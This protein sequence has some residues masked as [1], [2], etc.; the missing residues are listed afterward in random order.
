MSK[1]LSG[2]G[3]SEMDL[4]NFLLVRNWY[5]SVVSGYHFWYWWYLFLIQ[6]EPNTFQCL[7]RW[8]AT[9]QMC[10]YH[11]TTRRNLMFS[12]ILFPLVKLFHAGRRISYFWSSHISGLH[13]LALT[14][15]FCDSINNTVCKDQ[16]GC[17]CLHL[18]FS[19]DTPVFFLSLKILLLCICG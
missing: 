11:E 4:R 9:L 18:Y 2:I 17:G 19:A 6:S 3:L 13:S 15:G 7:I 10:H 16:F 1:Y 12:P 5:L 14:V 8:N